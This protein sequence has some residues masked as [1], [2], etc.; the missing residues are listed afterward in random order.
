[1]SA[2]FQGRKHVRCRVGVEEVE[3][4][5]DKGMNPLPANAKTERRNSVMKRPKGE[6]TFNRG[7]SMRRGLARLRGTCLC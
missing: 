3:V 7:S 5:R 1:V 6:K 4:R 2:A